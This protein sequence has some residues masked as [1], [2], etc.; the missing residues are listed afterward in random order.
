MS[1]SSRKRSEF[2]ERI[3]YPNPL[4]LPPYPPKLLA[5][6]TPFSRFTDP[7]RFGPRLA[8][9]H[10][11]PVVVDAEA[12]M[13][14]NLTDFP[15]AW[16]TDQELEA[17][18]NVFP[19]LDANEVDVDPE[20]AFLLSD[21]LEKL[22]GTSNGIDRKQGGPGGPVDTND[23]T[24]LRRTEYLAAEQQKRK[25]RDLN[26]RSNEKID[27]SREGQLARIEES[28]RV[29]NQPL[30]SVRHPTK[31]G[32]RAVDSFS[33]L[34]D[35]DTWATQYNVFRFGDPPGRLNDNKPIEDPR[36]ETAILRP[37]SD[38]VNQPI[39]SLFLIH[40]ADRIEEEEEGDGD[41]FDD[42][43]DEDKPK[44]KKKLVERTPEEQ[45]AI[46][47]AES[48][49]LIQSRKE[50]QHT[51]AQE[52]DV[53]EAPFDTEESEQPPVQLAHS[54]D[55][56]A[57][58]ETN[59]KDQ[60]LILTYIDTESQNDGEGVKGGT[61]PAVSRFENNY[62]LHEGANAETNGNS[63]NQDKVIYYHPVTSRA[64]LRVRRRRANDP[65]PPEH[66]DA[67]SLQKRSLSMYEKIER[68]H[69]RIVVDDLDLKRLPD[70]IELPAEEVMDEEAEQ[71]AIA[72]GEAAVREGSADG[73][74]EADEE[75]AKE[76]QGSSGP[77]AKRDR[78]VIRDDDDEDEGG[79][80][81]EAK[82]ATTTN[83]D[84]DEEEDGGS[85]NDA[86]G[87]EDSAAQSDED[88][89]ED[90]LAALQ[91][92]AG[93]DAAPE[94]EEEE[95]GGRR[96]SRRGGGAGQSGDVEEERAPKEPLSMDVDEED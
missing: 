45:M 49:R 68:L 3:R 54:K 7:R 12:G 93:E 65:L 77:R 4:P 94:E 15:Q 86:S 14:L 42:D 60:E 41:L 6:P 59:R 21:M 89:D 57:H 24:W 30:A 22:P 92:D 43:E 69:E 39:Y 52:Q 51:D 91:A 18:D 80:A 95:A 16:Y 38:L 26:D 73:E 70:K 71:A 47:N 58:D 19:R 2:I 75:E 76:R 1:S 9:S 34:P 62:R 28:F 85:D 67:V 87:S 64:A 88:M 55:Y 90:E 63:G 17:D 96:R 82:K 44:K 74:G 10:P 32:L 81:A 36:L 33:L 66:W 11:L 78:G 72:E 5:I 53:V 50:G 56:E 23:I 35:P 29:A 61:L 13:P 46:E 83:E 8:Q 79:G 40:A 48:V 84:D 20:D 27:S 25:K 37:H 31:A